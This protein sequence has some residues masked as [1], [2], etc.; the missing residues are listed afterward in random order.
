MKKS[1]FIFIFLT[2][3]IFAQIG[4][5][6]INPHPSAAID[7]QS[8]S[9]K[10]GGFLPPRISM[11]SQTD[12]VTIP[13]PAEG[14]FIYNLNSN[15]LNLPEGIVINVGTSVAPFWMPIVSDNSVAIGKKV[16]FGATV[17]SQILN[18]GGFEFRYRIEGVN[19]IL[20]CRLAL[21]PPSSVTLSGNRL[22]WVGVGTG[23]I[24]FNK[25]W[26]PANWN[27]WQQIDF[28][29]NGASH[30]FYMRNSVSDSFYKLSSFVTQN[31]FN[32]LIVEIY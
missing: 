4:I 6:N 2:Q 15:A 9:G 17:P 7:I 10:P 13:S 3:L 22:G 8:T 18:I 28:M 11:L 12:A 20:D 27:T 19:T 30:L 25:T 29:T 1:K 32:S 23:F 31:S 24:S 16:Y 5:N 14:L 26:T 21:I